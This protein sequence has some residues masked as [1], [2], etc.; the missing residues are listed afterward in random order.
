MSDTTC[1]ANVP[2]KKASQ[3][4]AKKSKPKKSR[5]NL[6]QTIRDVT[7]EL[8]KVSWPTRAELIQHTMVVI[9]FV[10]VFAAVIGIFDFALSFIYRLILGY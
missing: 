6:I 7:S 8:K 5:L 3:K 1:S 4:L 10:L 2:V 9:V